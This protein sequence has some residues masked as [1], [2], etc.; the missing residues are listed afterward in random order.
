VADVCEMARQLSLVEVVVA[1]GDPQP[2]IDIRVPG[3][4]PLTVQ[5]VERPAPM[6]LEGTAD[7]RAGHWRRPARTPSHS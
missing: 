6:T 1:V 3:P 4:A 7:L 5:Q 2:G